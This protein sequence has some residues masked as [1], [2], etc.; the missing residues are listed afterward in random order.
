M[1]SESHAAVSNFS[2]PKVKRLLLS[3]RIKPAVNQI[4]VHPH[5]PQKRLVRYYQDYGIY[6]TAFGPLGSGI[7]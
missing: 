2:T 1:Y 3:A 6:A 5:W 4:E 7:P